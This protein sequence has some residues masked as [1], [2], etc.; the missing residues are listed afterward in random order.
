MK[1]D[2]KARQFAQVSLFSLMALGVSTAFAQATA[3]Q[4]MD[5]PCHCS[6]PVNVHIVK[7]SGPTHAD[8]NDFTNPG[9]RLNQAPYNGTQVNQ[10]FTETLKWNMPRSTTCEL[11]GTVSIKL[12]NLGT[13]SSNDS[14]GLFEKGRALPGFSQGV[15]TLWSSNQGAGALRTLTYQLTSNMIKRGQLSIFVQDDTAVQEIKVDIT[16]CCIVPN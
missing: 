1:L 16:G 9:V 11:T 15:G 10:H 5:G 2:N 4:P 6:N 14:A 7:N 12:K 8:A 3:P 13:L